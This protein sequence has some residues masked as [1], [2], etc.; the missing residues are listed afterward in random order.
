MFCFWK[1]V[2]TVGRVEVPPKVCVEGTF[3]LVLDELIVPS[4][5]QRMHRKKLWEC[6]QSTKNCA[7]NGGLEVDHALVG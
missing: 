2:C 6:L 1:G 4:I 7:R 5:R 3:K